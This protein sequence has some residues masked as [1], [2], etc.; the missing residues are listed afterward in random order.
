[1]SETPV[2]AVLWPRRLTI[3]VPMLLV[4]VIYWNARPDFERP[5]D[6]YTLVAVLIGSPILGLVIGDVVSRRSA[7]RYRLSV[8]PYLFYFWGPVLLFNAVTEP[9]FGLRNFTLQMI[10]AGVA[11]IAATVTYGLS[12]RPSDPATG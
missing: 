7:T 4:G 10:V 11:L 9:H 12:R 1:M 3:L 2:R 5:T 6:G 8:W